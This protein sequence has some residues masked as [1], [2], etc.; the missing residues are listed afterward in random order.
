MLAHPL[1]IQ[2]VRHRHEADIR[3]KLRVQ[4]QYSF[5]LSKIFPSLTIKLTNHSYH[6][7]KMSISPS[8]QKRQNTLSFTSLTPFL[9]SIKR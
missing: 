6:I 1:N 3:L 2:N 9:K 7:K 5:L 4:V 8:L